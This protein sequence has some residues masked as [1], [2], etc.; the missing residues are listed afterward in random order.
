[1]KDIF[2][3][4]ILQTELDASEIFEDEEENRY[5]SIYLGSSYNVMPSGKYYL[6]FAH[7]NLNIC[8][9]CDGS[10]QIDNPKGKTK[11][12]NRAERQI[13]ILIKK[14]S[15]TYWNMPLGYRNRLDVLRKRKEYYQPYITCPICGGCGF[16]E[17]YQDELWTTQAEKELESI[18][19]Y[20]H[21]DGDDIFINRYI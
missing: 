4:K 5:Q 21:Y 18:N 7:S 15:D 10:G 11:S 16:P 2:N 13:K 6:P 8:E 3:L 9:K 17:A 1:M 14:L 19:A 12:Y 20:L